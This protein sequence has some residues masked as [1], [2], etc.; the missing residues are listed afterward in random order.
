MT[1]VNVVRI[2]HTRDLKELLHGDAVRLTLL[3]FEIEGALPS[4]DPA[5]E[6]QIQLTLCP[7]LLKILRP[8]LAG[9][10]GPSVENTICHDTGGMIPHG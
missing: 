9:D 6:V 8:I 7:D 5:G 4:N 3:G 1:Q 10:R 2:L